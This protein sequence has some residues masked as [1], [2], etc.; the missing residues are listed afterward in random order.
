MMDT[1]CWELRVKNFVLGTPLRSVLGT[2][3]LA[4]P[5]G[6]NNYSTGTDKQKLTNKN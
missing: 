3:C 2:S 5:T 4:A 6:R 1:A